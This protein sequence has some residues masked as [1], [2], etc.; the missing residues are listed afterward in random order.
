MRCPV[1]GACAIHV[2]SVRSMCHVSC[3]AEVLRVC[4]P[5]LTCEKMFE[6]VRGC[7]V[8]CCIARVKNVRGVRV[9][10]E[11]AMPCACAIRLVSLHRILSKIFPVVS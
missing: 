6:R 9:R 1:L 4:L 11:D 2:Q 8:L 3:L 10:G 5:V 7:D